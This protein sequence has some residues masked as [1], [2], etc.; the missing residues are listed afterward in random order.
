MA[1]PEKTGL[2][3]DSFK[4]FLACG[5]DAAGQVYLLCLS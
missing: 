4:Y 1:L 5:D 3:I 2:V